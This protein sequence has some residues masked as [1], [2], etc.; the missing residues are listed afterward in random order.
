MASNYVNL[1][2]PNAETTRYAPRKIFDL[3]KIRKQGPNSLRK[4]DLVT[5][6]DLIK[7]GIAAFQ[8]DNYCA[9]PWIRFAGS[10]LPLVMLRKLN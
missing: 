3:A 10:C 6:R 8:D 4:Q 5:A 9:L 2:A 1:R 7:R